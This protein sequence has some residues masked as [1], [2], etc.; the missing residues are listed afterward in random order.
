MCVMFISWNCYYLSFTDESGCFITRQY[1]PVSPLNQTGHFEI[2]IKVGSSVLYVFHVFELLKTV[3]SHS[4]S[5]Y[6]M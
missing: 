2:A 4:S 1:T 3:I 5:W 6:I